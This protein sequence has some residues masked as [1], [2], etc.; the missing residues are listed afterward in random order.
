M[1]EKE[2]VT[3]EFDDGTYTG[4]VLDGVPHG[5][6]KAVYHSGTTYEGQWADG[7]PHGQGK[8]KCYEEKGML[9]SGP[10][11]DYVGTFEGEFENGD[12][13]HGKWSERNASYEGD[14]VDGL[15]DGYGVKKWNCGVH[16][17]KGQWK[18][19]IYHGTGILSE[20][21]GIWEG[22]FVNGHINGSVTMKSKGGWAFVGQAVENFEIE[23][24]GTMTFENGDVYVGQVASSDNSLSSLRMHGKG[25]YTYRDGRVYEGEFIW[26][27]RKEEVD[28][29]R[30][31]KEAE[32]KRLEQERLE[33]ERLEAEERAKDPAAYDERRRR[34]YR[35]Y[36]EEKCKVLYGNSTDIHKRYAILKQAH[37]QAFNSGFNDHM[38]WEASTG[39]YD[40]NIEFWKNACSLK[41]EVRALCDIYKEELGEEE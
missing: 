9:S 19:G 37:F 41:Y 27:R 28:A 39:R 32:E 21:D 5:Q 23:G 25:T 24:N 17:Y 36:L 29:E 38:A 6:G 15:Y 7:L 12:F 8:V 10:W 20:Y 1:S 34:E 40:A 2:I 26:G 16:Y 3:I 18:E 30:K 22:Q 11:Y 35:E 4:E 14:F 33:A 31:A 13:K